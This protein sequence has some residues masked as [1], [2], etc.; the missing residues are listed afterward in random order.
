MKIF[1]TL[2]IPSWIVFQLLERCNLRCKMCYEWGTNGSYHDKEE[3]A[4]LDLAT[5][6][7]T[8]EECLPAK[9]KFE[10]FGGEPML[11]PGIWEVIRLIRQGG[12]EISFSTNGTLLDSHAER[13]VDAAPTLVWVSNDGPREINDRQRGH[14]VFDRVMRGIERVVEIRHAKGSQHPQLGITYVV[15][16]RNYQYIEQFFLQSI[17][18]GLFS[19]VS[20]ELQSYTTQQRSDRHEKELWE[21]FGVSSTPCAKGYI[22]DPTEFECIDVESVTWQMSKVANACAERGVFFYS[23]PRTLLVDNIRNYF[24]S[25]WEAMIDRRS[26]CGVP[27]LFAEISARGDVTTCH[28]FYDLPIGNI[29]EQSLPSIWKGERLSQ[30]R[31]YLRDQLFPICTACCHYYAGAGSSKTDG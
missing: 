4:V 20:I 2:K 31:A 21:K 25:N 9:P 8:V 17:D 28:T 10:F 6:L 13:L 26:R 29:Y 14:G 27:W 1:D 19:C 3:L 23:Q 7:R 12:S 24:T 18:I 15:T 5:V 16:P 22:R 30:V 11:Y